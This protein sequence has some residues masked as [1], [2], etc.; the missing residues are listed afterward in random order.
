MRCVDL[1]YSRACSSDQKKTFSRQ[2]SST[3]LGPFTSNT[4]TSGMKTSGSASAVS[5]WVVMALSISRVKGLLQCRHSV[6][7]LTVTSSFLRRPCTKGVAI[8]SAAQA[9]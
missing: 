2:K 9:A 6:S 3:M 7:T 1:R 8:A 5:T 4:A